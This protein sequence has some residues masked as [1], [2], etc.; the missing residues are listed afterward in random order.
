MQVTSRSGENGTGEGRRAAFGLARWFAV[1]LAAGPLV[2]PLLAADGAQPFSLGVL[3]RDGILLPFATYD[4]TRWRNTW[5]QPRKESD[6]PI[7][8]RDV[9]ATWWG[10]PGLRTKWTLTTVGGGHRTLTL[11]DPAWVG[12]QCQMNIGLR[13]DY[14][15]KP[16][17]RIDANQPYPKDGVATTAPQ[18]LEAIE[19]LDSSAP[20]WGKISEYLQPRFTEA[21]N[22][23]IARWRNWKH[24]YTEAER[25]KVR[26]RIEVL[27]RSSYQGP[28]TALYYFEAVKRYPKR[29]GSG[30]CGVVTFA[31]GLLR[32]GTFVWEVSLTATAT[33]CRLDGIEFML[34]L[35]VLRLGK[36]PLWIVQWGTWGEERYEVLEIAPSTITA[37]VSTSGGNCF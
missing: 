14:P 12:A 34:P 2:V 27:C 35:G 20:E 7:S 28:G 25:A 6:V 16:V 4:G 19:V 24:P 9:P 8:M 10:A 5:P 13:T 1:V 33:S 17:G 37:L 36:Q 23:A 18:P 21:E 15:P 30:T 22:Q 3:R 29:D 11:V 26:A 32:V 31:R